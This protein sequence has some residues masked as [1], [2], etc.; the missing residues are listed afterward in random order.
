MKLRLFNI[1]ML[2]AGLILGFSFIAGA[3]T[4]Q[5]MFLTQTDSLIGI[6]G[7]EFLVQQQQGDV[8]PFNAELRLGGLYDSRVAA[9]SGFSGNEDS[10]TAL[11]ARL[12]AGWQAP[13][14]G[15]FGLRLDYRGYMDHHQDYDEFNMIDQGFSLESQYKT[16]R[17]ILSL[18]FSAGFTFVDSDHEYNRYMISPTLT[19]LIPDTRQAVAFYGIGA[20]IDDRDKTEYLDEDGKTI[21]A[22]CAYL[23]FFP[24]KSRVRLSLDYQHT[25]YDATVWDYGF[26]GSTDKREN[27]AIA[28]GL[29]ILYRVTDHIGLYMNYAFIHSDSN[30][31]FFEYER[32]LVEG[33][34]AV[35]F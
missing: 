33:G 34:L 5:C 2:A 28:A 7:I 23:Y 4:C 15:D 32:H 10:D 19:Y 25:T 11:A 18:P 35:N 8:S 29:D 17:F 30:V 16:G 22:G 6:G 20:R 1:V 26:S 3:E 21:G 31:D 12:K 9:T 13:L 14:K 24:N 27:D